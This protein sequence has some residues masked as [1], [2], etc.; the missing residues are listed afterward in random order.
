MARFRKVGLISSVGSL[1][2]LGLAAVF[3][4][5][6]CGDD[7]DVIDQGK[8]L[9]SITTEISFQEVTDS[10]LDFTYRNGEESDHYAIIESLGGGIGLIDF[11]RDGLAD[12]VV[13]GG[14]NFPG[15]NTIV[16]NPTGLFRNLGNWK[17]APVASEAG[18]AAQNFYSHG[19]TVGDYDNDGFPDVLVTGYGGVTLWMNLGD[20]TF[21]ETTLAAGLDDDQWSSSAAWAD[22]NGD[23]LLDL[24]VAHYVNWSFENNPPCAGPKPGQKEVCP[25]REFEPLPDVLYIANGDG[26]FSDESSTWKLRKDGKGLGVVVGDV[27]LDGDVDVYVGNDTVPNFLYLNEGG[28]YFKDA[29]YISGTAVNGG[30][31]ADGSMGVDL[32]DVDGDG[33]P[34]LWVA[35]FES[36]SYALYRNNGD[37]SFRFASEGIGVTAVGALYVGWGTCF[38]DPDADGDNDIFASN[39]HVI[40]HP[41]SAPLKQLPL[42]F[43]NQNGKRLVNV[44]SQVSK[45]TATPHMGRGVAVGDLDGDGDQDLVVMRTNDPVA[46]LENNSRAAKQGWIAFDLTATV[47]NRSAIGAIVRLKLDDG[48][49]QVKQIKSGSSY[50]SSSEQRV[51]FGLGS[52][53][54][55]SA[56]IEWPNSAKQELTALETSRTIRVLQTQ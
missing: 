27:D 16:G 21:D 12:I 45:Y 42:V 19:V 34:D 53:V 54:P 40:R 1:F 30:G 2:V 38:F 55:T 26:S 31:T 8:H 32:G 18:I 5:T 52:K 48:S 37:S 6:G 36:E 25:P 56:T 9:E 24:Y 28:K 43:D 22:F 33:L 23:G 41:S 49:S 17:F 14:G 50:A 29:G 7:E 35:N 15:E 39:G 3:W 4:L 46:L 11:D 51:F 44:S 10:G 47:S 13:P 20:G